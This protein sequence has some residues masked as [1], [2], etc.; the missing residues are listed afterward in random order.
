MLFFQEEH[1]F[2]FKFFIDLG[3]TEWDRYLEMPVQK[4]LYCSSRTNFM[5]V[6]AITFNTSRVPSLHACHFC[7][8]YSII[9]FAMNMNSLSSYLQCF[10]CSEIMKTEIDMDLHVR[11]KDTIF[12]WFS[13]WEEQFYVLYIY[14]SQSLE[15]I[16]LDGQ[17]DRWIFNYYMHR[18]KIT[19][20]KK[21]GFITSWQTSPTWH[22]FWNDIHLQIVVRVHLHSWLQSHS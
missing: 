3:E 20:Q 21:Y 22:A 11:A 9:M 15:E 1:L 6:M 2:V 17:T 12:L 10:S 16:G 4:N 7:D 14:I 19:C 18:L 13:P 5:Y 8:L